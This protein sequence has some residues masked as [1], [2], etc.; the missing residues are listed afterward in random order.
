MSEFAGTL[1]ER[2]IVERRVAERTA[3]GLQQERWEQVARCLAAVQAD[4]AGP[5]TEAMALSSMPR[6][7]VTIRRRDGVSVGQRLRWRGRSMLVTQQIDDP[8]A[9][10]RTLLRCEEMR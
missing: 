1:R 7:R 3:S 8:M 10:D 2:I 4:G 9:P 6:F 5:E